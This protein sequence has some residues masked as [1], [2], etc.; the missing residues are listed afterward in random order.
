MR[1]A[2]NL[3]WSTYLSFLSTGVIGKW[4]QCLILNSKFLTDGSLTGWFFKPGIAHLWNK[5]LTAPIVQ[6]HLVAYRRWPRAGQGM[7]SAHKCQPELFERCK[8]NKGNM[9]PGKQPKVTA[10][11][12]HLSWDS[13]KPKSFLATHVTASDCHRWGQ[14]SFFQSLPRLTYCISWFD[15]LRLSSCLPVIDI[16]VT[17]VTL[18]FYY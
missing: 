10:V 5:T 1:L 12:H 11:R 4:R 6:G 13:L 17:G 18:L 8:G 2:S 3:W 14:I 15:C 16:L 7:V 9:T